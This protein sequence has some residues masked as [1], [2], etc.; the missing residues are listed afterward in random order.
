MNAFPQ[1][2]KRSR[3][4]MEQDAAPNHLE[5]PLST[6]TDADLA[7][8][9][10]EACQRL[11]KDLL[12]NPANIPCFHHYISFYRNHEAAQHAL[13]DP[14]SFHFDQLRQQLTKTYSRQSREDIDDTVN[15]LACDMEDSVA[16]VLR[17]CA[18]SPRY[19]TREN[20]VK[21]MVALGMLVVGN[22]NSRLREAMI[23]H[24]IGDSI[25]DGC[26]Q[27]VEMMRTRREDT[28]SAITKIKGVDQHYAALGYR[29]QPWRN[30]K[31]RLC[32]EPEE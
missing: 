25:V 16:Y 8:L 29:Y 10:R 15:D 23:E 13:P 20:G 3:T 17:S 11:L 27:V 31:R 1:P 28:R 7:Q 5:E 6:I 32:G 19:E 26:E 24:K 12:K 18:I 14:V 30:L 9:S 22:G 4:S 2:S 21:T